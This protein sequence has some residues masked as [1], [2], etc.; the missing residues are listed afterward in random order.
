M[1]ST[2]SI[3]DGSCN[4]FLDIQ[5]SGGAPPYVFQ[6]S[7]GATTEDVTSLCAGS[8]SVT[9]WDTT[10][11]STYTYFSIANTLTIYGSWNSPSCNASDGDISVTYFPNGTPPY[12]YQWSTGETT[13]SISNLAGGTYYVTVT[14]SIS[15]KGTKSIYLSQSSNI[16]YYNNQTRA[17][18]CGRSNGYINAGIWGGTSPYKFYWSNGD[19][20]ANISGLAAGFYSVSVVDANGCTVDTINQIGTYLYTSIGYYEDSQDP[21]LYHFDAYATTDTTILS[22]YWDFGDGDSTII[23]TPSHKFASAGSYYVCLTT[24][25]AGGCFDTECMWLDIQDSTTCQASYSYTVDS[26]DSKLYYFQSTSILDTSVWYFNW[27]FGD[28]TIDSSSWNPVHAFPDTGY[29]SVCLDFYDVNGCADTRCEWIQV[30]AGAECGIYSYEDISCIGQ[31]DGSITASGCGASPFSYSW[32]N[33]ATG[34]TIT[35]LKANVYAVTIID[36]NFTQTVD[37]ITLTE[38]SVLSL[39]TTTNDVSCFGGSDGSAIANVSG[40]TPPYSYFWNG[41]LGDTSN[42][43]SN[44]LT[45]SYVISVIDVNGCMMTSS[46]VIYEPS[47]LLVTSIVIGDGCDSTGAMID[48]T[49]TGGVSP[50]Y[51]LWS[52]GVNTEDLTGVYSGTYAAIVM[53]ANG[54]TDSTGTKTVIGTNFTIDFTSTDVS[55]CGKKDASITAVISGSFGTLSYLWSNGATTLSVTNAAA[56]IHTMFATDTAGC[57]G[58]GTAIIDILSCTGIISGQVFEDLNANGVKDSNETGIYGVYVYVDSWQYWSVTNQDGNYAIP[59]NTLGTYTI[60]VSAPYQYSCSGSYYSSMSTT[61]PGGSGNYTVTV[62]TASLYVTD[63]DFG[64]TNPLSQCGTISG[65]IFNDLNG[66]GIEDLGEPAITGMW[67]YVSPWGYAQTD[68]NGDYNFEIPLNTEYTIYPI[69]DNG[70]YYYC[71]S[72][73]LGGN[74]LT[75]PSSGNYQV[76]LTS[77]TPSM[78]DLDFGVTQSVTLDAGFYSLYTY[79]GDIPGYDFYSW[80]DFKIYT[81]FATNCT[82]TVHKD[83]LVTMLN[84]SMPVNEITD[85]TIQ[86]LISVDGYDFFHCMEVNYHLDA[87]AQEGDELYWWAEIGCDVDDYCELNN[88]KETYVYVGTGTG[89]TGA[90]GDNGYNRMRLYHTGDQVTDIITLDDS[91]FS[92]EI[93]FQNVTGDTTFSLTIRDT[94]P[95][96]LDASSV[97]KPFS[98]FPH[99]FCV[100]EPN[101]LYFEFNDLT[102]PDSSV[103]FQKSYGFVQFNINMKPDLSPGTQIENHATLVFNYKDQITTNSVSVTIEDTAVSINEEEYEELEFKIYPNPNSGQLTVEFETSDNQNLTVEL[104]SIDG[105]VIFSEN[106]SNQS[107]NYKKEFSL[108]DYAKGIYTLK[109]VSADGVFC[110]KVVYR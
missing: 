44:L 18:T 97:S 31:N 106:F 103:D 81:D 8:Y 99:T 48:M 86:W 17:A 23:D 109:V 84:S 46:V 20:T 56:G 34:N 87:L 90:A 108:T 12:I 62:D 35:G 1:D 83:P 13:S 101:I 21:Y 43:A 76:T 9:V 94:L 40:G 53:D 100:V 61:Y 54:C 57:K 19:T 91:T 105:R 29:Y 33:G 59:V 72:D 51:Y 36:A 11:D 68:G 50:Y 64:L 79:Y 92:Y 65:H 82:L 45:G 58:S 2:A 22:W 38:P 73:V 26:T 15:C 30:T 66:N 98:P 74:T 75:F 16:Y 70:Y 88:F 63:N 85:T 37:V 52:N 77:G 49:V 102:L 104:S 55:I 89:K 107:G 95:D 28:G 27:D 10:G 39:S 80:M 60:N 110:R 67:V 41:T 4:G 47:A 78:S 69:Y 6:W 32:S 71:S 25:I 7:T 3:C 96:Y 24:T 93:G 14:D 42:T 5:V